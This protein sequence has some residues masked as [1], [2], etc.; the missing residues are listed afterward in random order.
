MAEWIGFEVQKTKKRKTR[1]DG[2]VKIYGVNKK[3]QQKLV[4]MVFRDGD[5]GVEISVMLDGTE[6]TS[7]D[8]K[9]VLDLIRQYVRAH[10]LAT[11]DEFADGVLGLV[12]KSVLKPSFR[13]NEGFSLQE[14]HL[15]LAALAHEE[16]YMR[17]K[18]SYD[19]MAGT[20]EGIR[21]KLSAVPER[22]EG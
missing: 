19:V 2:T 9:R 4:V 8:E 20:F 5:G 3:Y 1:I 15:I 11:L 12:R 14:Y 21:K 13:Q 7:P 6:N 18:K 16:E 17:D 22:D 10:R